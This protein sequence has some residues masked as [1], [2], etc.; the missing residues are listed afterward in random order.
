MGLN[1]IH[2]EEVDEMGNTI[3]ANDTTREQQ[4]K[5]LDARNRVFVGELEKI[6]QLFEE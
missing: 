5:L 6:K 4:M 1:A 3:G 2:E